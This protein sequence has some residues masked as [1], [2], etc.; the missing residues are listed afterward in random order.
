MKL[1]SHNGFLRQELLTSL[2]YHGKLSTVIG[3]GSRG[4]PTWLGHR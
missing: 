4:L 1:M 3:W 2:K